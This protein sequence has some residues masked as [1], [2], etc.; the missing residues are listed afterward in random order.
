M[1]PRNN[2]LF[3]PERIILI[4]LIIKRSDG[5]FLLLPPILAASE[6]MSISKPSLGKRS[7]QWELENVL[8]Q[9]REQMKPLAARDSFCL[10]L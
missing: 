3:S 9:Q 4:T 6:H 8:S 5:V 10:L 1:T 2:P 7:P